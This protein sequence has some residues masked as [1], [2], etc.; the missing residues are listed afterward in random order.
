MHGQEYIFFCLEKKTLCVRLQCKLLVSSGCQNMS[1]LYLALGKKIIETFT[2]LPRA[3]KEWTSHS[4]MQRV[5]QNYR[6]TFQ[7]SG[8]ALIKLQLQAGS[9][10]HTFNLCTL[11]HVYNNGQFTG[12]VIL[13]RKNNTFKTNMNNAKSGKS[14][15]KM[16][17]LCQSDQLWYL[18]VMPFI[19]KEHQ[20]TLQKDEYG[21]TAPNAASLKGSLDVLKYFPNEENCNNMFRSQENTT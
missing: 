13:Y 12:I 17:W 2:G 6:P 15:E 9:Y 10:K 1:E 18:C 7:Q 14:A 16:V 19:N 8:N 21:D 20:N 11:L 4:H 3:S 5:Q